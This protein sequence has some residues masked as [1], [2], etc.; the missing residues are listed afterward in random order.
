MRSG[1][2][3]IQCLANNKVYIGSS[4]YIAKRWQRHKNNL[5]KKRQSKLLQIDYDLYGEKKFIYAILENCFEDEFVEKESFWI[6]YYESTHPN[7]GYN[8]KIPNKQFS[9]FGNKSI[10]KSYLMCYKINKLTGETILISYDEIDFKKEYLYDCLGYWS[11]WNKSSKFSYKG[12]IYVR[13]KEYNSSFDY[14][15]YKKPRVYKERI[16]KE[17]VQKQYVKKIPKPY[18][19]RA[20]FRVS[21]KAVRILDEKEFIFNSIVSCT[22]TLNLK[23]NKIDAVLSH[24][25]KKR[26]HKGYWFKKL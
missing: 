1:V 10:K 25:F 24:E 4:V 21:V 7:K 22:Q 26:S 6:N 2:Y 12:F 9:S 16:K 8:I 23:R 18:S 14:I 20:L 15:N 3:M 13:E 5:K 11:A 19:E 17:K